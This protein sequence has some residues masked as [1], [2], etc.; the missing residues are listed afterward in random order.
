MKNSKNIVPFVYHNHNIRIKGGLVNLTDLWKAAGEPE[1]KHDP[2]QWKRFAG[3]EFIDSVAQKLNVLPEHIYKTTRGKYG[4]SWVHW[5]IALAYAKY[6]SHDLHMH[7]N[8]V[9]MRY[10][11]GDTTLADEIADKASLEEQE[12][13]LKRLTGKVV[14]RHFT[15]TLQDHGVTRQV[16]FAICT[17]AIYKPLLGGTAR[18]LR[19]QRHLPQKASLRDDM[20]IEELASVSFAEVASSKK[21]DRDGDYGVDECSHSCTAMAKKISELLN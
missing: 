6:L 21:I 7:V 1:G 8:E 15:N 14:R 3:Q 11:A 16:E 20:S 17:N 5:Q 4:G 12:K 2:R 13:M 18:Q 9:Y 19:K 10:Q